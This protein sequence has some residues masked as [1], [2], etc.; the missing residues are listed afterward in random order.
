LLGFSFAKMEVA[1]TSPAEEQSTYPLVEPILDAIANWVRKYRY[2]AGLRNELAQCGRDEVARAARDLGVSPGELVALASKGPH[3]ADQ[4]P[5]MLLALGVDPKKLAS[6]DPPM[7]RDLQRL[8]IAC[9]HKK[10]CE[11]ELAAGTAGQN[12]RSFCPNAVSLDAL[13]SGM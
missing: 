11:H 13:L 8:C 4:L 2:A 5:K 7:M 1:M 9:A 3:A 12:Y 6:S 10:R